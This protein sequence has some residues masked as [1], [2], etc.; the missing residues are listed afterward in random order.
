M[1]NVTLSVP[2]K[3]H[4]VMKKHKEIRWTEVARQA[5]IK[6]ANEIELA[7]DPLRYHSLKRLAKEGDDAEKLF[8][9]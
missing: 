2:E 9:F 6:K 7:K 1:V 4:K 5:I 3:T 8:E